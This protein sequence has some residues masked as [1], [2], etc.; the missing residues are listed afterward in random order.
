[1]NKMTCL[2]F[3]LIN[4]PWPMDSRFIIVV[5]N[6]MCQVLY[7]PSECVFPLFLRIS[8]GLPWG[9][10]RRSICCSWLFSKPPKLTS[11]SLSIGASPVP[12]P[13][14]RLPC[15]RILVQPRYI[16][17]PFLLSELF[18]CRKVNIPDSVMCFWLDGRRR[19][20]RFIPTSCRIRI[21][22]I[23]FI[24]RENPTPKIS[25]STPNSMG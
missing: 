16:H 22:I 8:Y 7:L 9:S 15:V 25:P 19:T 24:C 11:F 4:H 1:M 14:H 13:S 3:M 17:C 21:L 23:F 6:M 18:F 12:D 10:K 2:S 5:V 20:E